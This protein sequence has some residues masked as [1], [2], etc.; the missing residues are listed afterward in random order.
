MA[1]DE[2]HEHLIKE[3]TELFEPILSDS[4][5][6]IYIYLDNSHKICNQ[7]FIEVLE[8]ESIEEWVKNENPVG[9]VTEADQ[10]SV[11]DAY[12]RASENMEASFLSAI[13]TTKGGS[14]VETDII[15]TP[16]SYKG[17][18]FVIHFITPKNL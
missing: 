8:Y 7:N 4:P 11:I 6:A 18:V 5:Q 1:H 14:E 3:I 16:F 2:H 13:W 15:M 10:N 12:E 9:D 17:E